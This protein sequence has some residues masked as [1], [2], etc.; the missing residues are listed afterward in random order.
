MAATSGLLRKWRGRASACASGGRAGGCVSALQ[1]MARG[2]RP[3]RAEPAVA[4]ALSPSPLAQRSRRACAA[5][6]GDGSTRHDPAIV[7]VRSVCRQWC[8]TSRFEQ[9]V[10]VRSTFR[11]AVLAGPF[12]I[13]SGVPIWLVHAKQHMMSP[14]C[15]C[16]DV[17]VAKPLLAGRNATEGGRVDSK[18]GEEV[19]DRRAR[20]VRCRSER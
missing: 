18:R 19:H 9:P 16:V 8:A 13:P 6:K 5:G 12:S 11:I 1:T 17:A 10:Q 7:K 15:L 4:N 14:T 2:S 3:C 20:A